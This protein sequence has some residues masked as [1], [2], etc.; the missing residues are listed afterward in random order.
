[1][2]SARGSEDVVQRTKIEKASGTGKARKKALN[3]IMIESNGGV[4][5]GGL[6]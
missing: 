4:N 1:M 6:E 5:S 3:R 2:K